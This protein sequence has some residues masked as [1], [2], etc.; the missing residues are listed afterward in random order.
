MSKRGRVLKKLKVSFSEIADVLKEA[1]NLPDE[2][3]LWLATKLEKWSGDGVIDKLEKL[4]N[5][6]AMYK[7]KLKDD[8]DLPF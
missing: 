7:E 4:S 1:L 6:V 5:D 2:D 3:K 8:D